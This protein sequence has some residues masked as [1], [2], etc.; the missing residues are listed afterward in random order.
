MALEKARIIYQ[1]KVKDDEQAAAAKSAASGAA[2][3]TAAASTT[4]AAASTAAAGPTGAGAAAAVSTPAGAA[5]G[6]NNDKRK[7]VTKRIDVMFNPSTMKIRSATAYSDP[8]AP[9]AKAE[10]LNKNP[11]L[12]QFLRVENDILTIELFFDTTRE[13]RNARDVR[14]VVK[15]ILNLAKTPKGGDMP[16][17][18]VFAWGEFSF[19]CVISSIDQ[20]YEYFDSSGRALRATLNMALI[21]FTPDPKPEEKPA[22]TEQQAKEKPAVKPGEKPAQA[23][24]RVNGNQKEW[25]PVYKENGINNPL[26]SDEAAQKSVKQ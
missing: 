16:P 1:E 21:G 6:A 14:T 20:T 22:P 12:K 4:G 5:E 3:S 2:A 17:I 15:P 23:A 25:R 8:K 10:D 19:P 11:R 18:L 9:N 13:G 26:D 7:T 24:E